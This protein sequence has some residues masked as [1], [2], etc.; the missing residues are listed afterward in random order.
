MR[1][2]KYLFAVLLFF[3]LVDVSTVI[4]YLLHKNKAITHN[5]YDT[6]YS[7]GKVNDTIK[8]NIT[9]DQ[10]VYKTILIDKE[11]DTGRSVLYERN[12]PYWL[13]GYGTRQLDD[14]TLKMTIG[15]VYKL[16]PITDSHDMYITLIHPLQHKII[17]KAR[18][19]M[20][21]QFSATD[22]RVEDVEELKNGE[23]IIDQLGTAYRFRKQIKELIRPGDVVTIQHRPEKGDD[24]S[25]IVKDEHGIE[26]ISRIILRRYG[27]IKNL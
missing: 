19:D 24:L 3:V 6:F 27:G 11:D 2:R 26:Y 7:E 16:E 9:F 8:T 5:D 12:D 13:T 23:P 1:S 10:N 20:T 25:K 22:I 21:S 17:L 14:H 4:Y 18:L 15:E